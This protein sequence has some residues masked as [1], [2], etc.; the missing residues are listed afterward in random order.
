MTGPQLAP[1][2]LA[3]IAEKDPALAA[4]IAREGVA[5]AI[6]EPEP[7][8]ERQLSPRT[9]VALATLAGVDPVAAERLRA[10][11]LDDLDDDA[12]DEPDDPEQFDVEPILEEPVDEQAARR[13]R[14]KARREAR[15]AAAE[16][17]DTSTWDEFW[18]AVAR[19]EADE[20]GE[21][22]T[23]T[24]RGV[25]V[26]VPHDLP[27]SFDQRLL[28]VRKSERIEDVHR[29]VGDLFGPHALAA[30]VEAGMTEREFQTVLLWGI[31]RGKGR[32]ITFREAYEA[33]RTQ[34]KSLRPT[35]SER[36]GSG[37][38]GGRSKRTSGASTGSRRKRS[39]R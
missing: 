17:A 35:P 32:E 18:A 33:V 24:I 8:P 28:H 14:K 13:A 37:P 3:A 22:A 31:G 36:P 12:D 2:V 19:E 29:L 30:W 27:L 25:T 38:S 15:K 34:G 6:A 1:E 7:E 9:E 11:L 10:Q 39:R 16:K 20:L 21:A 5:A 4:R 26:R 23:E